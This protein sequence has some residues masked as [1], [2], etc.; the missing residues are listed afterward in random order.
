MEG[1]ARRSRLR[2]RV[3]GRVA[4]STRKLEEAGRSTEQIATE[5]EAIRAAGSVEERKL[6]AVSLRHGYVW[7]NTVLWKRRR[8]P[9]LLV[10]WSSYL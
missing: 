10:S 4:E 6:N 1:A 3:A 9:F 2:Q 8:P 7:R 5:E